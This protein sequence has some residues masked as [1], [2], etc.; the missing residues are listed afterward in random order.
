MTVLKIDTPRWALP[1]MKPSRY[2]GSF[3]GRG[4]GKSH[5]YAELMIEA[6]VMDQNV[7]SVCVREVQRTL[8]QSVKRLL[9]QKIQDLGVGSYF[10][11]QFDCIIIHNQYMVAHELP[12]FFSKRTARKAVTVLSVYIAKGL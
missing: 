3:G 6:H 4:S 7:S 5:F 2:K 1:F 11:V 8:N 9:E 12:P 10:E